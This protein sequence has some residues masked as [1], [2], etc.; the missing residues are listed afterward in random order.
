MEKFTIEEISEENLLK[1]I[2]AHKHGFC[3]AIVTQDGTFYPVKT[4]HAN[5][6]IDMDN[7]HI[8]LK[9]AY[10]ITECQT[11][12][13]SVSSLEIFQKLSTGID[14]SLIK[15]TEEQAKTLITYY[16]TIRRITSSKSNFIEMLK[17]STNLGWHLFS[18]NPNSHSISTKIALY[19][20]DQLIEIIDKDPVLIERP[21]LDLTNL[22]E[23]IIES[24]KLAGSTTSK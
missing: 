10:R 14:A 19:N 15:L 4:T 20:I 21:D 5:L 3:S 7:Y 13:I 2:K 11:G 22:R 18:F 9:G 6:I 23:E 24:N 1:V 8:D 16:T 17:N 12:D